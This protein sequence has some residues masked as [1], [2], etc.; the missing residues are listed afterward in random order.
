MI[1]AFGFFSPVN[2]RRY[3]MFTMMALLLLGLFPLL[4]QGSAPPPAQLDFAAFR[5]QFTRALTHRDGARMRRLTQ[6]HPQLWRPLVLAWLQEYS[7]QVVEKDA[8]GAGQTLLVAATLSRLSRSAFLTRQVQRSRAWTPEQHQR[9]V[10][11]DENTARIRTAFDQ[12]RYGDVGEWGGATRIAY[13]G[14]GDALGESEMLHYLGQ[15]DRRLGNYHG[16][17]LH[18]QMALEFARKYGDRL[19]EG[20]ALIDLGDVCEREKDQEKA[21]AF[22]RQALALLRAPEDWPETGRA[23][24]QLG[25]VHVALG[26]FEA[27]YRDY[28]QALRY[29]QEVGDAAQQAQF[30]DYL[31]FCYR[32]LG[33]PR[34]A[35]EQHRLALEQAARLT[36]AAPRARA[37]ARAWNHLGLCLV[38]LAE[39]AMVDQNTREATKLWR[40]AL[41]YEEQARAAA[42]QVDDR[43]RLGYVLRT[44]S[45]IHRQL[46]TLL[47][48]EEAVQEY[49]CALSRA[50]EALEMAEVMQEREWRGLA[51]H[52]LGLAQGL[53]GEDAEGLATFRE[54]VALW[55]ELGDL[56]S[57]ALAHR[58]RARHFHEPRQ[59]WEEAR[60]DYEQMR[61]LAA[62][63]GDREMEGL[64]LLHLARL[65]AVQ[66]RADEA[67]G[68]YQ[69][70]LA[71][72]ERVRSQAGFLEF[73]KA[74]LEKVYHRYE[75][76]TLFFLG[77]RRLE[78]AFHCM[79]STKARVFLDQLAEARVNLEK[80]I[81][82]ALKKQRDE[83]ERNLARL[84]RE[85]AAAHKEKPLPEPRIADLSARGERLARELEDLKKQI[86]LQN[87]LYAAVH[88][89]KP[90]A[91]T[92]LQQKILKP[93]EILLEYF[94]SPQ[95]V[96]G[97]AVTTTGCEVIRLA[98]GD[99]EL[100]EEVLRFLESV[101]QRAAGSRDFDSS[102]A[103]KL[104]E[105]L[106]QPFAH[107]LGERTLIIVPDGI[108]A[109]LPFEMLVVPGKDGP[110]YLLERIRIKYVQSATVLALLRTQPPRAGVGRRFIGLGDPVYDYEN[111]RRRRPERDGGAGGEGGDP[112]RS[113]LCQRALAGGINL[114]RLEG[115]GAE[116]AGISRIFQ[117]NRHPQAVKLRQEAR[118]EVAKAPAMQQYDYI[119]L[120]AHGILNADFQA[121]VLSQLPASPEDGFLTLGEIM[122]CKYRAH[123][124]VLSACQTGLGS[125][126]R[127]E[128]VT[129]LTRAVMY[130]GSPA[131]VVSLWS[132]SDEGTKE[133]MVKFYENLI[134]RGLA[135]EEALRGAKL[136]LLAGPLRHP[137]FWAAFVMYGE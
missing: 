136:N 58:L 118:E 38:E 123:L 72:L 42:A 23:L 31:G 41:N 105:I 69:E 86:R 132:V 40:E 75:E 26:N 66:G 91:L 95:G 18:H 32:R 99:R 126:T 111:F 87:P 127:G 113:A 39:Q 97:F 11:G 16:A 101:Q 1:G 116:V 7:R 112:N 59:R 35:M 74:F 119:H 3:A 43:W 83:L 96:Y 79:E 61:L 77:Q 51:L 122:N 17:R 130:A 56:Y 45:L 22:Y 13:S 14:L 93:D 4:A 47:G 129:G 70:G 5:E 94:L 68:L 133:L 82:P 48:G 63:I 54:A 62:R 107:L 6:A 110:E 64:A 9:K 34:R 115:S 53:L 137:Y 90:I 100:Q 2:F 15:A 78:P 89:P 120:A 102:P 124:V 104:Y 29:A 30:H 65:S 85:L 114:C 92:E 10:E 125:F 117:A 109:R 55:Q 27:A 76:A 73:K 12:G 44:L 103:Q 46:G 19:G 121:I 21:M 84:A 36:D 52:Y 98:D 33:D 67:G 60:Q 128:G 49:R 81:A 50:R 106:L 88:Y 20:R 134:R 25:D 57:L 37:Q 80:G 108:L 28:R 24:R 8:A 131:V 71:R 135:K